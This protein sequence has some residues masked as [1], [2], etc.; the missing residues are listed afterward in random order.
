MRTIAF[1][2]QKGGTGKSTLAIGLAVV[3][4]EDGE[5][6]F[7]LETDPQGTV[8][9]W[10]ARRSNPEPAVERITNRFRLERALRDLKQRGYTLAII[11][12][13][14]SDSD[15]VTEAIR[16][17]DL[18]LIPARPSQA[19]IEAAC[20]T[21]KAIRRFDR[22]FAFVL[23]Q[24]PVRG[25]RP[26]RAATALNEVGM[27]ALPYIGMRNDH[28]DSLATG[29][30]IS[31]FASDGIAAAEVRTLWIWVKQIL[32]GKAQAAK[33]ATELAGESA[34]QNARHTESTMPSKVS[35]PPC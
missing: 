30:G 3:A 7:I 24:A 18:C 2:S 29:L 15:V 31:E 1:A 17:A 14:G 10:S 35:A 9:Y 11:D 21:L 25:Q 12:T 23:N 16:L 26:T 13:P 33:I 5:R 6:V 4:M 27:L 8:S 19:D 22:K 20:P 34:T 28:M 32:T